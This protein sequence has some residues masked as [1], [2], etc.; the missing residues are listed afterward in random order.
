MN[1]FYAVGF[2]YVRGKKSD[3][4]FTSDLPEQKRATVRNTEFEND[5]SYQEFMRQISGNNKIIHSNILC[6]FKLSSSVYLYISTDLILSIIM[7]MQKE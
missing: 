5:K 2:H 6:I 7:Y 3:E 4:V 1:Q